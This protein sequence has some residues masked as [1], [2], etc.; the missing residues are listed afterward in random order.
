MK[1]NSPLVLK[2]WCWSFELQSPTCT[3]QEEG[4][5]H[6]NQKNKVATMQEE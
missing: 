5:Y 6:T 1:N 2:S 4:K 3:W